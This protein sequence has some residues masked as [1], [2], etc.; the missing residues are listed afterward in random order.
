[1]WLVYLEHRG[2]QDSRVKVGYL[3][4]WVPL[5]SEGQKVEQD[6]RETRG[7]QDPKANRVTLVRWASQE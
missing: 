5:E 4:N 7:S 2:L 1:M 3:G 6:F